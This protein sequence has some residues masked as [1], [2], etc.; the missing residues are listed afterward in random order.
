MSS[1]AYSVGEF[2][3][4]SF[5]SLGS[6]RAFPLRTGLVQSDRSL[7]LGQHRQST[8]VSPQKSSH[9]EQRVSRVRGGILGEGSARFLYHSSF[10]E[11]PTR[12]SLAKRRLMALRGQT[13]V[14]AAPHPVE[15]LGRRQIPGRALPAAGARS[16]AT[17]RA[18]VPTVY[19]PKSNAFSLGLAARHERAENYPMP[20]CWRGCGAWRASSPL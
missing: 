15:V 17:K 13:A 16:N 9:A 8:R 5:D 7:K 3:T 1:P 2:R 14:S 10:T 18:R 20:S 11:C 6:T 4:T 19:A 12:C